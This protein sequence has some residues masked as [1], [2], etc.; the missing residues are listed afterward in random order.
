MD[1]LVAIILLSI[2]IYMLYLTMKSASLECKKTIEYRYIP[3]TF[4]EEQA[5]PVKPSA[6]F[7]D[8]FEDKPVR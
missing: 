5:D 7:A 8:M 1:Y 3:R 6:L 2:G 4:K